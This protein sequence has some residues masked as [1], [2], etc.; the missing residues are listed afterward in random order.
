MLIDWVRS[1]YIKLKNKIM[2]KFDKFHYMKC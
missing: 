1:K 2:K